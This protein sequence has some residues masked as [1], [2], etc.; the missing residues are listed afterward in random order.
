MHKR[1]LPVLEHQRTEL[2]RAGDDLDRHRPGAREDL[3]NA[4][5]HETQASMMELE[6][7]QRTHGLLAGIEQS[8]F[9]RGD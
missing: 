9:S 2:G 4:L 1:D 7:A 8:V 5:R 3:H 6:G